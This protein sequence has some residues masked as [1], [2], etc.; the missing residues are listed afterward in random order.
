MSVE[1]TTP[2][3]GSIPCVF[4]SAP[5]EVLCHRSPGAVRLQRAQ[6]IAQTAASGGSRKH[7][8]RTLAVSAQMEV[9]PWASGSDA[10]IVLLGTDKWV[11]TSSTRTTFCGATA[12]CGDSQD[13][14]CE[15]LPDYEQLRMHQTERGQ[16]G[17]LRSTLS[18]H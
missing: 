11:G 16:N 3:H 1:R 5:V 10:T 13:N 15:R 7:S 8:L 2:A 9:K 12:L 18:Q 6:D 4:Q 17:Q 14:S